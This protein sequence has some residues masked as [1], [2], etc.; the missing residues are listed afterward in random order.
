MLRVRDR[1]TEQHDEINQR[2]DEHDRD[3]EVKNQ[4]PG[5]FAGLVLSREKVHGFTILDLRFTSL[6]AIHDGA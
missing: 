5:F 4:Q 1:E 6:F 3:D 2:D